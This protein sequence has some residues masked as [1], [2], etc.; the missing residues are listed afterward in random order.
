MS[1][2]GYGIS[3]PN[4]NEVTVGNYELIGAPGSFVAPGGQRRPK[5][6]VTDRACE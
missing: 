3:P 1:A 6:V 2:R 4:D 5:L